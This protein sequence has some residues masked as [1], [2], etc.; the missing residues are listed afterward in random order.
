MS[1]LVVLL[2]AVPFSLLMGVVT[3]AVVVRVLRWQE[4]RR[5][6]TKL[7]SGEYRMY[8]NGVAG[9]V[10]TLSQTPYWWLRVNEVTAIEGYAA[11]LDAAKA[12]VDTEAKWLSADR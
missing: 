1:T 5:G 10:S 8:R 9:F 4:I 6:W 7:P 3:T 2:A 11:T 12:E